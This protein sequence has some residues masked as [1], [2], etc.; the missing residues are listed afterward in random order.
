MP[1][2][3][4]P[5]ILKNANWQKEKGKFAKLF[6]RETG[7]G[8]QMDKLKAAAE[9]LNLVNVS[10]SDTYK[11]IEVLEAHMAEVRKELGKTE[12]IRKEAYALRDLAKQVAA[13]FKKNKL[14]PS[15]TTA[16]VEAVSRAAD[17][18]GVTVK[19]YDPSADFAKARARVQKTAEDAKKL[20]KDQ[21]ANCETAVKQLK[22]G[23]ATAEDYEKKGL[24][25]FRGLG[26]NVAKNVSLKPVH[27]E[28]KSLTS[29][30][31]SD[32]KTPADVAA[33]VTKLEK[34]LKKTSDTL[35]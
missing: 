32:L 14:I 4:I 6:A 18:Y 9:K 33:H 24:Q 35:G 15:S 19:S 10:A 7:I 25:A 30:Q 13:E 8:G 12:P 28:W 3:V 5:D 31:K 20:V 11:S 29:V 21:M 17:L 27:A 2:P 16:H 23:K 34:L 1:F 22:G 26:A